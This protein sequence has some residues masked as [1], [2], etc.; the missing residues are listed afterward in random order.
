MRTRTKTTT[1]KMTKMVTTKTRW[2][3]N[4]AACLAMGALLALLPSSLAT[5]QEKPKEKQKKEKPYALIFGTAYGPNDRPLY[6]V[7]VTI[8][9]EKKKHPSW[10]LMSDHRGEFAQRVPAGAND[11]LVRGE[12]EYAPLGDDGKPQLSKKLRLKGETRVHVDNEERRD[13]SLHL[14]E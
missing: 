4:T 10:D 14:T 1:K 3:R 12:A 5:S 9:P 13:I 7:K 8:R 6:G 2:S 11:Y